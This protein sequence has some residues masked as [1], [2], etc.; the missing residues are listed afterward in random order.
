MVDLSR[1]K[2][3]GVETAFHGRHL[4]AQIM[5]DLD[6]KN[7]RLKDYEARGGYQAIRKILAGE[8]A[9]MTP[10]QVVAEVKSSGMKPL[11]VLNEL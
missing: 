10:D 9:G 7:W 2:S 11:R 1:F 6:G 8:G 5:A 4:G 3:Q